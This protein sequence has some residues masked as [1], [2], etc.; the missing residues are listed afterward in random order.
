M[1]IAIHNPFFLQYDQYKNY[2]GYNF[3][4]FVKY[5]PIIYLSKEKYYKSFCENIK[6]N[7]LNYQEYEIITSVKE[8]N[9]KADVLICFNGRPDTEWN[10]PPKEFKGL[11]I[12]HVMDYVFNPLES[13]KNL[14]N[15]G[16]DYVMGYNN[17]GDFCRFFKRYYKYYANK[18]ISVPFGYGD[19][20]NIDVK[21][22][23]RFLKVL[24]IGSVN[25]VDDP[26]VTNGEIDEYKNF[27]SDK[28]WTHEWR[29]ILVENEKNL[30]SVLKSYY[31]HYPKTK[32]FDYDAVNLLSNYA[33]FANDEGLMN[34]PPARTY[35]G[36]A[37]GAVMVC[38]NNQIYKELGFIDG[39]NC[40][41]HEKSNLHDFCDKVKYYIINSSLLQNISEEGKN[42]VRNNY[43][44]EMVA[45]K[46][47]KDI[48][49]IYLK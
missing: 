2:N 40:I 45:E 15:N 41:F 11:K 37:T 34:F 39:V 27:Y 4:F 6:V 9:S 35:E 14:V 46:L 21:F 20:F 3:E 32:D 48:E 49:K 22:T 24:G 7:R 10:C 17:H 42:L 23:E 19:R 47:Y 12:Y 44:H 25:P 26:V 43:L 38:T 16:V 33:M 29:R 31:P 13:N 1:K 18:V 28:M 36:V 5:K 8:L 30:G